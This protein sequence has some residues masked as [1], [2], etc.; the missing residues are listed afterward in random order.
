MTLLLLTAVTLLATLGHWSLCVGAFNRAAGSTLP[1]SIVGKLEKLC[2]VWAAVGPFVF[3]ALAYVNGWTTLDDWLTPPALPCSAYI[4]LCIATAAWFIPRWLVAKLSERPLPQ[5]VSND[6]TYHDVA[7]ELGHWPV[8]RPSSRLFSYLPCN[9][10]CRLALPVKTLSIPRLPQ[11]LAGLSI[12]HL[13]DL[14]FTGQLTLDYYNYVVD[15]ANELHGDLVVLTGDIIDKP[16]CID[17]IPQ[18][19]GRLKSQHGVYFV[20]GNHDKRLKDLAALRAALAK[21]GLVDVGGRV[22]TLDIAGLPVTLA[23]NELPWLPLRDPPEKFRPVGPACRSGLR[24]LLAHSPDQYAWAREHRFDLMLAG[25]CHGGQVRLPWIGPIVSPSRHGARYA[26]GLF[27]EPPTLL[28]VTRGLSGTH[29][30]RLNCPPEAA[31]LI[32]SPR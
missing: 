21:S 4:L 5:L 26:S 3:A 14:H 22:L 1:C 25:H 10:I 9:Q 16:D 17:W 30:L 29:P 32:L 15:R 7:R 20:L 6:T 18:T 12:I 27:F 2:L 11:Q 23:G 8:G 24:I 13:S 31:K 28:H 19:L